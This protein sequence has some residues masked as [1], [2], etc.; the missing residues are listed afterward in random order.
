MIADPEESRMVKCMWSICL[1]IQLRRKLRHIHYTVVIRKP[2][3]IFFSIF[4][5]KRHAFN[6]LAICKCTNTL[7]QRDTRLYT[8]AL[9]LLFFFSSS[10]ICDS[11]RELMSFFKI[12]F[13]LRNKD[14][15]VASICEGVGS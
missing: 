2:T 5:R 8:L 1:T 3:L 12:L 15:T 11:T 4:I 13:S 10:V 7:V 9:L 6:L 14:E